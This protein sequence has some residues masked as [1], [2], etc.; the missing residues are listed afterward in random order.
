M[1]FPFGRK[2]KKAGSATL[3]PPLRHGAGVLSCEVLDPRGMPLHGATI[4]VTDSATR[5]VAVTSTTDPFGCFVTMLPPGD[6]AFL[7]TADSLEPARATVEVTAG[8][9]YDLGRIRLHPSP[10]KQLPLPGSWVFDPPHTAIRF[11]AQ[12]VGMAHKDR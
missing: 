8:A 5:S 12:H 10:V 3:L 4:T 1:N 7:V 9:R 11:V 6:Y 2:Y